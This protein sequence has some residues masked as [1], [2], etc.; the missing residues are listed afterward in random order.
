MTWIRIADPAKNP[1]GRGR[2]TDGVI[3]GVRPNGKKGLAFTVILGFE[4]TSALREHL[5]WELGQR[6][7]LLIGAPDTAMHGQLRIE[8]AENGLKIRPN[9]SRTP[10]V[11]MISTTDLQM[12]AT[13][14]PERGEAKKWLISDDGLEMTLPGR[15]TRMLRKEGV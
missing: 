8:R 14:R 2:R 10:D 3:V 6:V 13:P 11:W 7:A 15:I 9:G 4:A 5:R 12:F 1:H